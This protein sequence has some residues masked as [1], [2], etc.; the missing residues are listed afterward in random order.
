MPSRRVPCVDGAGVDARASRKSSIFLARIV[1]SVF[2]R[3]NSKGAHHWAFCRS[4]TAAYPELPEEIQ[5]LWYK[6]LRIEG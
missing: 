2:M 4:F 3:V 5:L 6:D 1:S